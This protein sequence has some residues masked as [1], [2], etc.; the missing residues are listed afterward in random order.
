MRLRGDRN[1]ERSC[2]QGSEVLSPEGRGSFTRLNGNDSSMRVQSTDTQQSADHW[3]RH[4]EGRAR[5][6][7]AVVRSCG[8]AVVWSPAYE[9][10]GGGTARRDSQR[11][12]N[13]GRRPAQSSASHCIHAPAMVS[14]GRPGGN[15]AHV[16][17]RPREFRR[18]S[19]NAIVTRR[20]SGNGACRGGRRGEPPPREAGPRRRR[21]LRR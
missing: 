18:R 5:R 4:G 6:C 17:P 11:M 2:A 1:P 14:C 19:S 15:H 12:H 8:R 16:L 20:F 9:P 3:F 21:T 7:C 10:A 13:S